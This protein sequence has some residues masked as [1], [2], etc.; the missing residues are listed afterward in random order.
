MQTELPTITDAAPRRALWKLTSLED[1]SDRDY[2][3]LI[4]AVENQTL[5]FA[6]DIAA[7]NTTRR[8]VRVWRAAALAAH[9]EEPMPRVTED[10]VYRLILPN[11]DLRSTELERILSCTH[12]HIYA[13]APL[14]TIV[15]APAQADGPHSFSVFERNSVIAFLRARRL[16]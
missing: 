4:V 15:R 16:S 8:E 14:W 7:P 6:W 9:R 11:R 1:F 2:D 5:K 10:D 3:S 12:Q 13:L